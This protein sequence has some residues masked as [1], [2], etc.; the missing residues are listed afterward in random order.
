MASAGK[1]GLLPGED[2]FA[3]GIDAAS[4][5]EIADELTK[6]PSRARN[7]LRQLLDSKPA[8]ERN[9]DT[10]K[11]SIFENPNPHKCPTEPNLYL[12]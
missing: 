7:H 3:N 1:I 12:S 2:V 10:L 11:A 5:I 8:E 6:K 9:G 4:T